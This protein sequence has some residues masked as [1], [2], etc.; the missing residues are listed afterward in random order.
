MKL[1]TR[2]PTT[3]RRA[4]DTDTRLLLHQQTERISRCFLLVWV[5]LLSG[6][7]AFSWIPGVG[8]DEDEEEKTEPAEL[9]DFDA[10]VNVERQWKSKVGDGLG[11]QIHSIAALAGC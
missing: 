10:E 7:A 11:Q 3:E 4:D 8:D 6:C 2:P 9:V 5:L 1:P